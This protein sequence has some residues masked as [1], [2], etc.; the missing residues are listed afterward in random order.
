MVR[1]PTRRETLPVVG[2]SIR[3]PDESG[4]ARRGRIGTWTFQEYTAD[5]E[6]RY[7]GPREKDSEVKLTKYFEEMRRRGE[8]ALHVKHVPRIRGHLLVHDM[9]AQGSAH[10]IRR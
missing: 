9:S 10:A 6:V 1:I 8:R 5:T 2:P 7:I 4:Q 3:H